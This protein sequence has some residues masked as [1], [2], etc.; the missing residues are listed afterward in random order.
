MPVKADVYDHTGKKITTQTL[1][2]AIF[3]VKVNPQLLAL[4]VRV[5]QINQRQGTKA[6]QTRGQVNFT[7]A[8]LWRQKGTGRARHG[9]RRAPVFVGGGRAHGP[10]GVENFTKRLTKKMRQIALRNALT[11]KQQASELLLINN[12]EKVDAKTKS[13]QKLMQTLFKNTPTTKTL[14]ILDQPDPKILRATGNLKYLSVSQAHRINVFEI[15]NHHQLILTPGALKVIE[16]TY[17][18]T[19]PEGTKIAKPTKSNS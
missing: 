6:T 7:G 13:Y 3:D 14:L 1:N 18:P 2:K 10:T 8:K 9:S 17:A 12:L 11:V 4:A 19:S 15:L 5:Y 16:S